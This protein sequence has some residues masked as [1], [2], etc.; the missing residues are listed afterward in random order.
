MVEACVM[1]LDSYYRIRFKKRLYK[2]YLKLL[3]SKIKRYTSERKAI[4]RINLLV[5]IL[6]KIRRVICLI[7][8]LYIMYPTETLLVELL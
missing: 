8:H 1:I 2:R 3:G 4:F 7:F 6:S 5:F